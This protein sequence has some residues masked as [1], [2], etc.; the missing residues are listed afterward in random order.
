MCGGYTECAE[1]LKKG[2]EV[3]ERLRGRGR[4]REERKK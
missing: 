1:V 4:K 3:R 2:R